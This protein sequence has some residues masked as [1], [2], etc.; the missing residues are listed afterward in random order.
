MGEGVG[1]WTDLYATGVI[2][3]ELLCG[4]VPFGNREPMAILL[5]HCQEAPTPWAERAPDV[6]APIAAWV[7]ALLAKSPADRPSSA[8]AAWEE[9]EE[10]LLECVGPRWRRSARIEGE[11]GS[12]RPGGAPDHAGPVPE[13]GRGRRRRRPRAVRPPE[14]EA[15]EVAPAET[16]PPPGDPAP[17]TAPVSRPPGSAAPSRRRRRG[18]LVGA[19]VAA[20]AVLGVGARAHAGPASR[21][22]RRPPR[23]RMPPPPT[24]PLRSARTG[25]GPFTSC[26]T[27][28][29]D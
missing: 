5:A 17:P 24:V 16:G 18:L 1:P 12:E 10:H 3:Y 2:A 13:V 25:C 8:S 21:R 11:P 15:A 19:G 22:R 7:H 4:P 14:P 29:K 26:P 6:P 23:P 27:N 20:L 9:L 28:P